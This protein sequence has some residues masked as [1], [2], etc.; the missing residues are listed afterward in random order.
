MR[1]THILYLS[2]V[3]GASSFS[4]AENHIWTLL[5]ALVR[6]GAE[7][8]L[9]AI[10]WRGD[11]FAVTGQRLESLAALSVKV[12]II[13][14]KAAR[15]FGGEIVSRLSVW[16]KLWQCL[17]DRR[18]SIIHLHLEFF[19]TTLIARL[20]GCRKIVVSIHNDEPIYTKLL[21]RLRLHL[22]DHLI[23]YYIAITEH[24]RSYYI[25]VSG[26]HPNRVTRIYYGIE[27]TPLSPFTRA[28]FDIPE[29]AF[30][31]GF[32]GRLV[33]Q[34]NLYVLLNALHNR[35]Q[36]RGVI[37]GDGPE[38]RDLMQYAETHQIRNVDFLGAIPGASRLMPVFDVFCL[39]SS[40]EGL[41]L[42]LLEAMLE[43]APIIGS[44]RGAIPEILRHGQYGLIAEPTVDGIGQ[45]IDMAFGDQVAL[46]RRAGQAYEYVCKEFSVKQMVE[47]TL[48]IYHSLMNTSQKAEKSR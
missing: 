4:G 29:N 7:V 20:A 10:L 23:T 37:V 2:E 48:N 6:A 22:I 43:R 30:V 42:V 21:Y 3:G 13:Q 34:K 26:A 5:P 25:K 31:V 41:G 39:P 15:G 27:K 28:D 9:V 40:W 17:R 38:K 32:V 18:S 19:Y 35:P 47:G 1:V 36:L 12:T 8:E 14:R 24:V 46:R 11:Q 33:P 45:A 16:L 44:N